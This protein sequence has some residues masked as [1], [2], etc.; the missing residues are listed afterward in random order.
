MSS[1]AVNSKGQTLACNALRSSTCKR[2]C[3]A[4]ASRP[5]RLSVTSFGFLMR[6]GLKKPSWLPD[7]GASGNMGNSSSSHK[8]VRPSESVSEPNRVQG[9]KFLSYQ[10]WQQRFVIVLGPE[11][12]GGLRAGAILCSRG[13]DPC[14]MGRGLLLGDWWVAAGL[15][16]VLVA[17]HTDTWCHRSSPLPGCQA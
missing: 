17:P 15:S 3:L 7:F 10:G 9:D 12:P 6:L 16:W 1:A 14:D 5:L 4:R 11:R 13:T 8:E 2:I